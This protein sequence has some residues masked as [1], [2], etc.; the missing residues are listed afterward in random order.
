M[1]TNNKNTIN[2]KIISWNKGPSMIKNTINNLRHIIAEHSPHI[3]AVQEFN[4]TDR[5]DINQLSIPG[6][7][8]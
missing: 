1:D 3:M 7:K 8:I 5:D 2:L 6:Y 4:M